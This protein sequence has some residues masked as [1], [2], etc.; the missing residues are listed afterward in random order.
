ML[1]TLRGYSF[2]PTFIGNSNSESQNLPL[3]LG[4]FVIFTC[5]LAL[6]AYSLFLENLLSNIGI[7]PP[8]PL[9]FLFLA[10]S[11]YFNCFCE[12]ALAHSSSLFFS[13]ACSL[14]QLIY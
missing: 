5:S 13:C 2:Y 9:A 7:S 4:H 1:V 10:M 3:V 11:L 6:F 12:N 14:I 8:H